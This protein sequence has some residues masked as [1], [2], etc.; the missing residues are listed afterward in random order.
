MVKSISKS[1]LK[2]LVLSLGLLGNIAN[3]KSQQSGDCAIFQDAIIDLGEQNAQ[4]YT[5]NNCC[6][7]D[8][9][10]CENNSITKM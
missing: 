2:F 10:T 3:V 9:I 8:G 5:T 4:R 1:N 6:N 7:L